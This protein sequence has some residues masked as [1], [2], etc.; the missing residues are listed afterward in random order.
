MKSWRRAHWLAL[1]GGIAAFAGVL[2]LLKL[3]SFMPIAVGLLAYLSLLVMLRPRRQTVR[4][5]LP[6]DV[7]QQD[8]DLAMERLSIGARRLRREI[9]KAP[10]RDRRVI[11][12]MADLIERIREHHHD[13]PGHVSLT[14]RFI[15]SALGRMVQAVIDYTVLAERA[16]PE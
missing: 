10:A 8:F 1:F 3:R 4:A 11:S 16:G 14:R 9:P 6:A 7:T 5:P 15:R 12:R 13:N 2:I